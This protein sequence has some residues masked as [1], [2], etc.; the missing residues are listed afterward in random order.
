MGVAWEQ[1]PDSEV[2]PR[3]GHGAEPFLQAP[4]G[5]GVGFLPVATAVRMSLPLLEVAGISLSPYPG[6]LHHPHKKGILR[7][8]F[9]KRNWNQSTFLIMSL[10]ILAKFLVFLEAGAKHCRRPSPGLKWDSEAKRLSIPY[11]K[12][13]AALMLLMWKGKVSPVYSNI[14]FFWS[15]LTSKA[16]K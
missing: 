1:K 8:W 5:S 15:I 7:N 12:G 11:Q 6:G 14:W 3:W 10:A 16:Q 13:R 2:V 9:L 4:H